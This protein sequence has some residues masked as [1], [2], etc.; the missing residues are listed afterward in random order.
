MND[1][2]FEHLCLE[3][4]LCW[5]LRQIICYYYL[6]EVLI[7]TLTQCL[8]NRLSN[9]PSKIVLKYEDS[10]FFSVLYHVYISYLYLWDFGIIVGL[11][12]GL[13]KLV[14]DN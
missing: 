8:I 14:I 2:I 4:D 11:F 5:I 1:Q 10:L 3:H 7:N 13:L 9:Y 12:F 6:G